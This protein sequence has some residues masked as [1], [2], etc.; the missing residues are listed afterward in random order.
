MVWVDSG[1]GGVGLVPK[2]SRF[3]CHACMRAWQYILNKDNVVASA[4]T[5]FWGLCANDERNK[6]LFFLKTT[7]A[8]RRGK[9]GVVVWW[10]MRI[11]AEKH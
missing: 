1:G 6:G 9:K 10:L 2:L 3:K 11:Q 8:Q 5:H 7:K 4:T